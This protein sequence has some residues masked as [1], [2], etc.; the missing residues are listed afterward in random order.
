MS[1]QAADPRLALRYV[2]KAQPGIDQYQPGV[3]L[4]Q[5]TVADPTG[6]RLAAPR[7]SSVEPASGC[8]LA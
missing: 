8:M 1:E 6:K 7:C 2:G 4:D 5:Q 3:G